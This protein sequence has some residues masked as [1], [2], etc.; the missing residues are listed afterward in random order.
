MGVE[1]AEV[2]YVP[3]CS[4]H[5]QPSPRAASPPEGTSVMTDHPES[6]ASRGFAPGYTFHAVW[7]NN[8]TRPPLQHHTA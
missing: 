4:S 2:P 7:I 5:A 6:M 3:R 8:D 1:G